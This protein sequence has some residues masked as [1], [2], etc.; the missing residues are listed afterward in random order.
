MSPIRNYINKLFREYLVN[1]DYFFQILEKYGFKLLTQ[2]EA[3]EIN[4]PS[5]FGS[6]EDL[7]RQMQID[8][9]RGTIK[10]QQ[11]GQS[12][13]MNKQEQQ[14]SFFNSFFVCKKVRHETTPVKL[15]DSVIGE[16]DAIMM[17]DYMTSLEKEVV[18]VDEGEDIETKIMIEDPFEVESKLP[19]EAVESKPTKA[20]RKKRTIAVKEKKSDLEEGEILEADPVEKKKRGRP[21]KITIKESIVDEK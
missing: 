12:N 5:S 4:L 11:I 3:R 1:Y 15:L 8:L 17:S 19:T 10:S 2:D 20:P 9:E 16:E 14:I 7:H 13:N 6:F 18:A 21:K